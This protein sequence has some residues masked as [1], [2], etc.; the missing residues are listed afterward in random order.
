MK[1]TTLWQ[2]IDHPLSAFGKFQKISDRFSGGVPDVL[3]SC[4]GGGDPARRITV[5]AGTWAAVIQRGIPVAMELK[6]LEGVRVL[7]TKFRPGQLDF[8]RDWELGGGVSLILTS[9]GQ[10]VVAFRWELGEA[11]ERGV[12]PQALLDHC[13]FHWS[14]RGRTASWRDFV[15]LVLIPLFRRAAEGPG[16]YSMVGGVPKRLRPDLMPSQGLSAAPRLRSTASRAS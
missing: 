8:L 9:H 14:R 6:E 13:L 10:D 7:K 11:L 16:P 5:G 2:H 1:E 3:G 15:T 4:R 12:S